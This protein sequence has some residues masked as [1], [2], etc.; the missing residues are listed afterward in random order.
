[1]TAIG[2]E[3]G[4]Y[5]L[6]QQIIQYMD[7]KKEQSIDVGTYSKDVVDYSR[8]AKRV[9]EEISYGNCDKGIL[10]CGTGIAISI[11]A[12]KIRSI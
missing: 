3:H 12:N 1:M 8:Y 5:E 10:I 9:C 4:G 6:K 11:A 2:C 7:N